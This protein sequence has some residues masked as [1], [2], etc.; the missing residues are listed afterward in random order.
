MD[1]AGRRRFAFAGSGSLSTSPFIGSANKGIV[2]E[3][4]RRIWG[5]AK[6]GP[7][8][9]LSPVNFTQLGSRC[10]EADGRIERLQLLVSLAF[11]FSQF[12]RLQLD[13]GALVICV[14]SVASC[15]VIGSL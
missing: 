6:F 1:S 10:L 13:R 4:Y 9:A 2:G 8:G 5:C 11:W 3:F 12:L 14:G 7:H 15:P